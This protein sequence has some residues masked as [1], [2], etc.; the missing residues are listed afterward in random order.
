MTWRVTQLLYNHATP[1]LNRV[2][3]YSV[4]LCRKNDMNICDLCAI[5]ACDVMLCSW[6]C[7]KIEIHEIHEIHK[8]YEIHCLKIEIHS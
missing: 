6:V 1:L 8:M 5:F 7:L 3:L 2:A 4:Q